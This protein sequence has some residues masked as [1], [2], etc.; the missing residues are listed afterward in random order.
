MWLVVGAAA[1]IVVIAALATPSG[2]ASAYWDLAIGNPKYFVVSGPPSE[3]PVELPTAVRELEQHGV[4]IVGT[5]C[6]ADAQQDAY[7]AVISRHFAR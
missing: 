7:N 1:S 2:S 6:V 5:G 3:R 4:Q